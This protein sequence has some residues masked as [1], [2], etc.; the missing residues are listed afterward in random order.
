MTKVKIITV[1]LPSTYS[2]QQVDEMCLIQS[3]IRD[4]NGILYVTE[5][6][7]TEADDAPI[8]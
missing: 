2:Q 1:D 3:S 5:R 7:R 4:G 8:F 6:A